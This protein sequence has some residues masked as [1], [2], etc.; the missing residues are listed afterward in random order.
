MGKHLAFSLFGCA[1]SV[2]S[3][4]KSV[5]LISL[6]HCGLKRRTGANIPRW[7]DTD[8]AVALGPRGHN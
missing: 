5:L 8:E 6:V 4:L 2:L 7:I 3:T 1:S